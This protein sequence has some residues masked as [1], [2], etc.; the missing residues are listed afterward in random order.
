MTWGP[1]VE[2]LLSFVVTFWPRMA[3]KKSQDHITK[4]LDTLWPGTSGPLSC[5]AMARL[6]QLDDSQSWPTRNGCF[7]KQP[8]NKDVSGSRYVAW[9]V[10]SIRWW[11]GF[12]SFLTNIWTLD[13]VCSG[14]QDGW[15][16]HVGE[17]FTNFLRRWIWATHGASRYPLVN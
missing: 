3:W 15:T 5:Y 16:K 17:T 10:A 8:F 1:M 11:V 4:G 12:V 2:N 13:D 7:S 9:L 6:F 14:M